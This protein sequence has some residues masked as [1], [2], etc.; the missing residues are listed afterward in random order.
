[1]AR[2][3][4]NPPDIVDRCVRA[5]GVARRLSFGLRSSHADHLATPPAFPPRRQRRPTLRARHACPGYGDPR[6]AR[7]RLDGGGNPTLVPFAEAGPPPSGDR[8]RGRARPGR[9]ARSFARE[10]ESNST[11]TS[12]PNWLT[13]S[14]ESGT[15]PTPRSPRGWEVTPTPKSQMP[16]GAANAAS[17]RSTRASATCDAFP[18]LATK[19]LSCFAWRTGEDGGSHGPCG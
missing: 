1:M 7:R 9:R 14:V 16:R 5:T 13:S 10:C 3:T 15:K 8:L 18:L 4:G 17:S 6:V 19:G 12:P 2:S 11:R